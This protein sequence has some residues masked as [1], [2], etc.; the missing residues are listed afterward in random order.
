MQ[1]HHRDICQASLLA[2]VSGSTIY[3]WEQ[4][5]SRPRA[6]QVQ[7]L[8]MLKSLSRKAAV[9]QIEQARGLTASSSN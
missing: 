5:K 9:A 8:G 7:Q 2:G 4:E 3:L 6:E 1:G